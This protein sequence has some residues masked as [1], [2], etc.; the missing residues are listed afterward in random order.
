M[1]LNIK[2][3]FLYSANPL[4]RYLGKSSKEFTREDL[5]GFIAG[6]G[7]KMLNFRYVAEDGKLKVLNF[8]IHGL[9]YL[10]SILT[11]GERVDGSSLF[12]YIGAGSSDL[13][14]IPRYPTAFLNPFSQIPT[15]DILCSF[16]TNTGKPLETAPEYILRKAN[17]LFT[18]RTGFLFKAMGE[19]EYYVQGK[20]EEMYT[21][22]DQKGY[23]L[24]TPFS[25]YEYIRLEA[26]DLIARCGGKI[27]YGHSEV[28]NFSTDV[29]SFEQ[30]EIE[31]LPVN[32]EDAVDQLVLAKWILRQLGEKYRV[33]IS[34]APKITVGKAGSGLHIHMLMEKDGINR[35]VENNSLSDIAKRVIAGLMEL[36]GPLTAFG[37]TIPTSYLRLVPH[38]EAPTNICWGDRNRSVLVRVP[39]GWLGGAD[40]IRD[41]NP[42]DASISAN[43]IGKQTVELRSP[44]G[45]AD[46][47]HLFAGLLIAAMRGLEMPDGLKKA[48]D[49]Y[50][51]VNIFQPENK[52]RLDSLEKLP[53]CCYGSAGLLEKYRD[54]FEKDGIFPPQTIDSFIRKL[55]SYEDQ[56]LSERL[57]GKTDEIRKLVYKYLHHM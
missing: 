49:L 3:G 44:D 8:V 10:N 47:Y 42:Q 40:M 7:I 22:D 27:K 57:F 50:V 54:V 36:A 31:F 14:V 19:L 25:N 29:E 45:S 11:T 6:N 4:E 17:R 46:L 24:S 20:K 37:N 13:Y 30:H 21:A 48:N 33:N 2:S 5:V 32:P 55:R 52:P 16:Y 9:D 12:S 1:D 53:D 43:S 34:F 15:L 39:L 18:E 26:M 23:H 38:Q 41:A 35:M 56:G 51:D 28:G